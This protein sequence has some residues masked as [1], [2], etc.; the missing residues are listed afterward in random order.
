MYSA[1][2][3]RKVRRMEH[4]NVSLVLSTVDAIMAGDF[5]TVVDALRA[6]FVNINDIGAGPW[7]EA[8]SRDEFLTL[9]GEFA[10]VFEGTFRLDV[11]DAL[12]YDDHVI[13][14]L[15]ETGSAQ[16]NNF[17][18][19]AIYL[20]RLVDGKWASL[21]TLDMDRDSI[22]RFWADVKRAS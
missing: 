9:F 5:A 18:N 16:G 3:V 6:D 10:A 19:R 14:V 13:L 22:Q 11:I 8:H 4:P 21:R 1:A 15:H 2:T 17:D 20:I 7:R 12:G